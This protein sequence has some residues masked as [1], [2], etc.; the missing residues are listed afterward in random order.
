MMF[1][2]LNEKQMRDRIRFLSDK[3]ESIWI[4]IGPDLQEFDSL[5]KE[6]EGLYLELDKRGL[7]YAKTQHDGVV[8][9]NVGRP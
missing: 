9:E 8:R 3:I 5:Q 4:K 2:G 7:L 6:F 1:E